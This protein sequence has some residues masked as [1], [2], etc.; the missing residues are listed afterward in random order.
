MKRTI[1]V[2]FLWLACLPFAALLAG[3]GSTSI[4]KDME[5]LRKYHSTLPAA[6]KGLELV[7]ARDWAGA[8][9]EFD[10][11]L[12]ILPEHPQACYGKAVISNQAGDITPALSWIERA[13]QGRLAMKQAW[14]NQKTNWLAVSKEDA[15]RL[16]E[17]IA[18]N[19]GGSSTSISCMAR[20]SSS[21]SKRTGMPS[22]SVLQ[23]GPSP[24]DGPA[25][26][27]AFHGNLLFKLRRIDEA[28]AKYLEA[29]AV[30]PAHERCLNNLINIYFVS[31]R[32]GQAREWLEKARQ[33]KAKINPKLEQAVLEAK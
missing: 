22:K 26:F 14:E 1:G 8:A 27:H 21:Q 3:Q 9:R 30:E 33:L 23:E 24:F 25:E 13:E 5:M 20:E 10:R 19:I 29:L 17:I 7:A 6:N 18:Q 32:L 16:N 31:R 2:C 12:A 11:C 28:E 4:D 15:G